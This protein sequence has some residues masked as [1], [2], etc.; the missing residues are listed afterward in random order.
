MDAFLV[1]YCSIKKLSFLFLLF[2]FLGSL[3]HA[4]NSETTDSTQWWMYG[5]Y[6]NHTTFDGVEFPHIAGMNRGEFNYFAP[7]G[8]PT[9]SNGFV[10]VNTATGEFF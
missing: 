2:L 1:S 7:V 10:Y 8:S 9:V 3:L 6:L 4:E 5:R